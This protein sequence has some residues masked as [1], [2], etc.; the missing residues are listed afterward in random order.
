[1]RR[2]PR[3]IALTIANSA[4]SQL[5][6]TMFWSDTDGPNGNRISVHLVDAEK[7]PDND[8][9][10]ERVPSTLAPTRVDGSPVPTS[11]SHATINWVRSMATP[12][13]H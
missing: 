5:D 6:P 4:V 10:D 12:K 8:F 9:V 2:Q 7:S 11:G 13:R 3:Q 1:M